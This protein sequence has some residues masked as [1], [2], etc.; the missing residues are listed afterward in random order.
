[1]TQR[2]DSTTA[3][4]ESPAGQFVA[5]ADYERLEHLLAETLEDASE[6]LRQVEAG[7]LAAADATTALRVAVRLG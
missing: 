6:F 4:F 3:M 1:M 7:Q 5:V 2:F